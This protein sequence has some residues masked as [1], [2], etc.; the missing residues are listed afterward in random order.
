MGS[1]VARWPLAVRGF[2][3]NAGPGLLIWGIHQPILC[4]CPKGTW[5]WPLRPPER[6]RQFHGLEARTPAKGLALRRSVA[7]AS[8]EC[9]RNATRTAKRGLAV[10]GA[11]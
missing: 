3:L 8:I 7:E 10:S 5:G 1:I 4:A 2:V 6:T 9:C 11:I